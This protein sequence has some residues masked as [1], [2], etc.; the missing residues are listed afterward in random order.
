MYWLLEFLRYYQYFCSVN[1]IFT[2]QP[3]NR[4]S[5]RKLESVWDRQSRNCMR[6]MQ[7]ILLLRPLSSLQRSKNKQHL[8]ISPMDIKLNI[9]HFKNFMIPDT[10]S[11]QKCIMTIILQ[12]FLFIWKIKCLTMSLQHHLFAVS[13]MLNCLVNF[14]FYWKCSSV[15]VD[16][17]I[18][19][20]IYFQ[21]Y[22]YFAECS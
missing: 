21:R 11:S 1:A 12:N 16:V 15:L 13:Q 6:I 9:Y 14:K 4:K 22:F 17:P 5:Q 18:W 20:A 19:I 10:S 2:H 7:I 8:I 3:C